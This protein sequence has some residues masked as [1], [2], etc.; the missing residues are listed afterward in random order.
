MGAASAK[1]EK[2]RKLQKEADLS[3]VPARVDSVIVK[4]LLR[5]YD[6]YVKRSAD[7]LF[8]A[9]NFQDVI[10]EV[11][12]A[13]QYLNDLGIFK[14]ISVQIDVSR[15]E[16]ATP[17]G[18]QITFEGVELS[19]FVG[20]VGTEIGQNEG[21]F[22]TEL[23]S[24]NLFGRGERLTLQGA[25][26]NFRTSDLILKLSKGFYHTRFIYNRPELSLS[27]FRHSNTVPISAYKNQNLGILADLTF[28]TEWPIELLHSFQ[29]ESSFREISLLKKNAPFFIREQCGPRMASLIRHI[30]E[31]DRRDNI[32][33]PT[34]GVYAKTTNEFAGGGLGGNIGYMLNNTQ[35]EINIPL[36]LGCSMQFSSRFGMIQ[37][38][39]R[40]ATV[41]ISSLF[42]LGGPMS[43]RGFQ[44]GGA[45]PQREGYTAG[46][47]SYWAAGMHFWAP[48]PFRSS[49]GRFSENFRT[50]LFYNFGNCNSFSTDQMKSAAGIGLAYRFANQARIEMNYCIPIDKEKGDRVTRG[51]QF[52]IGCDFI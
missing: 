14:E 39:K 10:I 34:Y 49:L 50:H 30:M 44:W 22:K 32:V 4:G 45:G 47:H 21:S 1:Q 18:Y 13:R 27:L 20:S 40:S 23:A 36:I 15:G 29:Y 9:K 11:N 51:F 24:P 42:N 38:D 8:K 37:E 19:R 5:T 12:N 46:A 35:F 26:S 7:D 17:N 3:T 48:L 41:P 2:P 43:L 33:F 25:Y 52:G 31:Y 28:Y 6:D 16:K